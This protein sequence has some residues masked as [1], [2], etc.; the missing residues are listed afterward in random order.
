MYSAASFFLN[1][2]LDKTAAV[3]QG[4]SNNA[5]KFSFEPNLSGHSLSCFSLTNLYSV[6][7]LISKSNSSTCQLDP[8]PTFLLKQCFQ[9]IDKISVCVQD[10]KTWLNSN[11]LK[12]N[13]N[14]T[15]IIII[16]TPSLTTKVPTAIS[17]DIT[18]TS[19]APSSIVRNLGVM[20]DPSL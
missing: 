3:H 8:A 5:I 17:C 9:Q 13:M 10:I 7:E 4:F 18:D 20:F 14:K 1:Y 12:L 11:F 16:G 6:S 19:I 2:F 15:E